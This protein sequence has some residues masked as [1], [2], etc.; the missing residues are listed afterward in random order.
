MIHWRSA[1]LLWCVW[2]SLWCV[3]C[4]DGKKGIDPDAN[5][6]AGDPPADVI[7]TPDAGDPPAGTDGTPAV[8]DPPTG[9]DGASTDGDPP[10]TV[11]PS[12]TE[13][14]ET[15][16]I[17]PRDPP[18]GTEV[19]YPSGMRIEGLVPDAALTSMYPEA[20][21]NLFGSNRDKHYAQVGHFIEIAQLTREQRQDKLAN[22]FKLEEYVRIPEGNKDGKIYIDAE[23][24]QHTQDLRDAWGRPLVLSSTYRSPE[25]NR[26]IGGATFSR[27]MYGDAVDIRGDNTSKAMDLYN[28]A[29]VLDVNFIDSP[30]NTIEGRSSPWLHL[31]DRGWEIR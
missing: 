23:I 5:G 16:A 14:P 17:G 1:L 15:P 20:A 3:A 9:N 21:R 28:L 31:D 26:A 13:E 11:D 29:R 24:V 19:S 6:G 18:Y 4:G 10:A 30:Q 8:G 7:E 12:Q 2:S 25:Y 22:N 27:H